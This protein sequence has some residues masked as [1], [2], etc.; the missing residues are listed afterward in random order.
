MPVTTMFLY[1]LRSKCADLS[2]LLLVVTVHPAGARS[3]LGC[4]RYL[5]SEY[6]L[7]YRCEK[8]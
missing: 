5:E 3:N 2:E 4:S 8:I 6:G 7:A 1:G